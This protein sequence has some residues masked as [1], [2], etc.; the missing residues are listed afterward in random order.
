MNI[1]KSA[2]LQVKKSG[3]SLVLRLTNFFDLMNLNLEDEVLA[4]LDEDNK[5]HIERYIPK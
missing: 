2:I 5:L 1:Q 3:D 4:Q